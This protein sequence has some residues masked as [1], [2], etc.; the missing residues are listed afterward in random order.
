MC[1]GSNLFLF[2]LLLKAHPC[3]T[4]AFC[5]IISIDSRGVHVHW[6]LR[7]ALAYDVIYK[8]ARLLQK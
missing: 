1:Y 2:K 4:V 6:S 3:Y 8:T 7:S 5:M